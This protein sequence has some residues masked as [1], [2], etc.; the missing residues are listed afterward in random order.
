M[1]RQALVRRS[2]GPCPLACSLTAQSRRRSPRRRRAL[3]ASSAEP[4]SGTPGT[5]R[6]FSTC[7]VFAAES[8]LQITDVASSGDSR[9]LCL[10]PLSRHPVGSRLLPEP[11]AECPNSRSQTPQRRESLMDHLRFGRTGLDV[12]QLCLGTMSMG[13]SAWK[14]WV[15][16][17]PPRSR[18][19]GAP[20]TSAST[21]STWPTG[22]PSAA[23]RRSS[24]ATC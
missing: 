8:G 13:S 18:S 16:D 1:T 5:C 12:S 21:S 3:V 4:G 20:S 14:G 22:I 11:G 10:P 17:E 24:A 2:R 6:L 7:P 23:T 19:C 9:S 15:L